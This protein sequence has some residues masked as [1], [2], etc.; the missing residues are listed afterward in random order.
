MRMRVMRAFAEVLILSAVVMIFA[1]SSSVSMAAA[2]GRSDFLANLGSGISKKAD[3]RYQSRWTL[4]DWFETQRKSRLQDMWLA[5]NQKDDLYEFYVGGRTGNQTVKINGVD[6]AIQPR[7]NE[8]SAGAYATLV[9]LEGRYFD[10]RGSNDSENSENAY[11][12]EGLLGFRP[13]GDSLQNSNVT[14]FYGVQFRDD[15]GGESVQNQ[16]AKARMTIYLTRAFGLEGFYQWIFRASTNQSAEVDGSAIDA[17]VFLDFS[18]LR[19]YGAWSQ[20]T[21]I[22][23]AGSIGVSSERRR[24]SVDFG[25]K[26]FF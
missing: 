1:C 23:S 21:R 15:F 14:L 7:R 25:L 11:G 8:A 18:L 12:W 22:R 17:S 2:G 16:T 5:G 24:E 19:I 6:S 4:A 10:T 13:I 26:L 20:E 9:G 3:D